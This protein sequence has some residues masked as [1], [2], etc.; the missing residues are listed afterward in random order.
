MAKIKYEKYAN[1]PSEL[2]TELKELNKDHVV[3]KNI[4]ELKQE[5]LADYTGEFE[6]AAKLSVGDQIRET[7]IRFGKITDYE[8]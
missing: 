1:S 7:H 4:H 6:M 3:D 2:Q 5:N 8:A